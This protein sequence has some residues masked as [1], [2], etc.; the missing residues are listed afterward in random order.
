MTVTCSVN[1]DS[2]RLD[3]VCAEI[4]ENFILS[5]GKL[6]EISD[7]FIEQI[8]SGLAGNNSSLAM[9]PAYVSPNQLKESPP[10]QREVFV[11]DIG[12]SN[13]RL[14]KIN[15]ESKQPIC[16]KRIIP[17]DMGNLNEL[18]GHNLFRYIAVKIKEA[19]D[20]LNLLDQKTKI[21]A[22]MAFNF[23][24]EQ[25][26]KKSATIISLGRG[27]YDPAVTGKDPIVLLENALAEINAS[28]ISFETIINDSTCVLLAGAYQIKKDSSLTCNIGII[29]ATETN[30]CINVPT[31][32]IQKTIYDYR[33]DYMIFITELAH[34]SYDEEHSS[35]KLFT[36]FDDE[37]MRTSTAPSVKKAGRMFGGYWIGNLFRII[38]KDTLKTPCIKDANAVINQSRNL[39]ARLVSEILLHKNNLTRWRLNTLFDKYHLNIVINSDE[40]V[41]IIQEICRVIIS[42]SAR[43]AAAFMTGAVR[44]LDPEMTTNHLIPVDGSVYTHTPGFKETV[45]AALQE[46]GVTNITI[47]E[48]KYGTGIGAAI[49][50]A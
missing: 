28:N 11:I 41:T 43:I 1:I 35:E 44:Y 40:E 27:F 46:L 19:L 8:K 18:K 15:L 23:R 37:V 5:T 4:Q 9:L 6:Q 7:N 24:Y 22:G 13:L 47:M 49:A 42:R 39:L 20:E 17:H 16:Y 34:F 10:A 3:Q 32:A 25:T 2:A 12:G 50:A 14:L 21:H 31:S 29:I 30:L 26:G 33:N 48:V 38:L 45:K 36:R